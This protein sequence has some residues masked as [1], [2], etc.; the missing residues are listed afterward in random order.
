MLPKQHS[1]TTRRTKRSSEQDLWTY[2]MAVTTLSLTV[3]GCA[4]GATVLQVHGKSTP[5][6]LTTLAPCAIAALAG[7]VTPPP[8]SS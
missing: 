4:V 8:P 5:E 7:M 1:S 2:R 3:I 6:L